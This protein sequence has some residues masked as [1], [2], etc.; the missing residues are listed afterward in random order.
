[1]TKDVIVRTRGM[2][3]AMN[4]ATGESDSIEIVTSGTFYEKNNR[5]YLVY[6]EVIEGLDTTVSNMVKFDSECIEVGKTGPINTHMKFKTG[7][8]NLSN[9]HTMYGDLMIGINTYK[10]QVTED[11]NLIH[12]EAD[13]GLDIN[14]EFLSDCKICMD[15]SPRENLHL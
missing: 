14:Y 3:F 2:Q 12:I 6:E 10:V 13:Y 4:E 15:I 8:Q 1:M 5:K 11:E 9:Y 7:E